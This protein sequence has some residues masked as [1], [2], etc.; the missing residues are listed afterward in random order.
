M[1]TTIAK[2]LEIQFQGYFMC[3]IATDPDPTN[4]QRGVSGYTLSLITE[5]PLDQVI[6]RAMDKNPDN[7]HETA[8][9]LMRDAEE[10]F[11]RKTRA[12][13]APPPPIEGP[14]DVGI[15]A[16]ESSVG[17]RAM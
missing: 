4:E 16:P 11:S 9:E 14:Q 1:T 5:A 6:R 17:T 2:L 12:A 15:R 13:M 10:A 7:R 8:S 3:R